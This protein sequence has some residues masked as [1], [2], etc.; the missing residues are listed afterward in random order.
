[1]T[2]SSILVVCAVTVAVFLC[3]YKLGAPV[4]FPTVKPRFCVLPKYDVRI[5]PPSYLI[6][7]ADP[8]A[9]LARVLKPLGFAQ[10]RKTDKF[11]EFSRGS[12]LGDFSVEIAKV[13]LTFSLPI[14]SDLHCRAVYGSFAAFDTGD[15][16]T[17]CSELKNKIETVT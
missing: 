2:I 6:E 3:A 12:L 11:S 1:M 7:A 9:E 8:T 17:L 14:I 5:I 10:S 15:L 13:N 4:R 16:W